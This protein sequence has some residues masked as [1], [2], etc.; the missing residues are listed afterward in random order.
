MVSCWGWLLFGFEWVRKRLSCWLKKRGQLFR[1]VYTISI[2]SPKEKK[3][4]R[5]DTAT[6]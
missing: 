4:Y 3:R 2:A 6:R 5:S 1:E